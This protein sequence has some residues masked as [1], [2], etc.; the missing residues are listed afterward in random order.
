MLIY[1]SNNIQ[2]MGRGMIGDMSAQGLRIEYARSATRS[3]IES[4]SI[5][6]GGIIRELSVDVFIVPTEQEECADFF[7]R[8]FGDS[9]VLQTDSFG[10]F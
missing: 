4:W 8:F 10:E 2:C 5:V 9:E 6:L 7:D 3:V 1:N